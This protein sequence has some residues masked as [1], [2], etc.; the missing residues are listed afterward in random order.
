MKNIITPEEMPLIILKA[1]KIICDAVSSDVKHAGRFFTVADFPTT[2]GGENSLMDEVVSVLGVEVAEDKTDQEHPGEFL[3]NFTSDFLKSQD[4]TFAIRAKPVKEKPD[5]EGLQ[6]TS[7]EVFWRCKEGV[8]NEIYVTVIQNGQVSD[9][10]LIM[11][12]ADHHV[13]SRCGATTPGNSNF[14]SIVEKIVETAMYADNNKYNRLAK[15]SPNT[16]NEIKQ[17]EN[18]VLRSFMVTTYCKLVK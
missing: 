18:K 1:M 15:A 9:P 2:W 8:F 4:Q 12:F 11:W 3:Y 14:F 16:M 5:V 7:V 17:L 6:G 10:I 13:S